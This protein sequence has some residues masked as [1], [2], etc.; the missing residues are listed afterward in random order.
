MQLAGVSSLELVVAWPGKLSVLVYCRKAGD[1]EA[2]Q[3]LVLSEA[4]CYSIPN[5][6][7]V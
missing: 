1:G 4:L 7:L 6:L 5:S 3:Y 2:L